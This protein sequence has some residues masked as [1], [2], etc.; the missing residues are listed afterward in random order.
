MKKRRNS[1]I[2]RQAET[3]QQGEYDDPVNLQTAA[4]S[5]VAGASITKLTILQVS[6]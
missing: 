6:E 5:G 2:S 3:S 4:S 1:P